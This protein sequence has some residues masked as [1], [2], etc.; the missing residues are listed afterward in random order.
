MKKR[1]LTILTELL[2]FSL[3]IFVVNACSRSPAPSAAAVPT[4][5]RETTAVA[6]DVA[7]TVAVPTGTR[8]PI[9][10]SPEPRT[11]DVVSNTFHVEDS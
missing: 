8:P 9:F 11:V 6:V 4:A 7:E 3:L 1:C 5:V 2:L 10:L